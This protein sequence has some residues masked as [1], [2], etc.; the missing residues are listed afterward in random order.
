MSG[1]RAVAVLAWIIA[2]LNVAG[3]INPV[4][5]L[6]DAMA[7]PAGNFRVSLPLVLTGAVALAV[8][9]WIANV[10]LRLIGYCLSRAKHAHAL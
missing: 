1:S 7:V 9:V 6:P 8:F 5:S 10:V 3:L 4:A 2:A